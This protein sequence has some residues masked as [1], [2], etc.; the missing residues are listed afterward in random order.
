MARG[1]DVDR[2]S[3]NGVTPRCGRLAEVAW[4]YAMWDN[5]ERQVGRIYSDGA[6]VT[7]GF[8]LVGNRRFLGG[9]D[10]Q[11]DKYLGQP[12]SAGGP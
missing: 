11:D 6:R 7:S 12:E 3:S 9:C 8:D 10:G 2:A 5:G 4:N 1:A